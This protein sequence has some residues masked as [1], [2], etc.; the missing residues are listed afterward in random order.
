MPMLDSANQCKMGVHDRSAG[1][2]PQQRSRATQKSMQKLENAIDAQ[3]EVTRA[4]GLDAGTIPP[5]GGSRGSELTK[6]G[7]PSSFQLPVLRWVN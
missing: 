5:K 4:A 2:T 3:L 1:A 7:G 6:V